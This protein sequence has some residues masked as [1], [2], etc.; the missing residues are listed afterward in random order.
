MDLSQKNGV[1]SVTTLFFWKFCSSLRTSH[2]EL[3]WCT[4]E[5]NTHIRTFFK[6]LI[7]RCFSLWVFLIKAFPVWGLPFRT[8]ATHYQ[9]FDLPPPPPGLYAFRVPPF[10]TYMVTPI[11]KLLVWHSFLILF[12]TWHLIQF[13]V[14]YRER[15]FC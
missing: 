5:P 10:F 15:P 2:K 1:F 6:S 13:Q 11:L 7:W 3:I 9:L 8:Y 14:A 4:N 12:P